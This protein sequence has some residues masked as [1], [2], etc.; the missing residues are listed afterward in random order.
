[1]VV[2]GPGN[3]LHSPVNCVFCWVDMVDRVP[4]IKNLFLE[5]FE[6]QKLLRSRGEHD[7]M[8]RD[9]EYTA[10]A[11]GEASTEY[12]ADEMV[13]RLPAYRFRLTGAHGGPPIEVLMVEPQW[14]GDSYG[15]VYYCWTRLLWADDHAPFDSDYFEDVY[16][17]P[18]RDEL[19]EIAK[20][21]D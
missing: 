15:G 3:Y 20:G 14:E 21:W 13:D 9:L 2:L 7:V 12:L 6:P 10:L 17:D 5:I 1:M 18:L 11:E 19:T 8:H 16:T 4:A